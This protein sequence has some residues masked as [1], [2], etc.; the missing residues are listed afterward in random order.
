MVYLCMTYLIHLSTSLILPSAIWI[1]A[2][3][4]IFRCL[5]GFSYENYQ[6]LVE[7]KLSE[8]LIDRISDKLVILFPEY[9][10]SPAKNAPFPAVVEN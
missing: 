1:Y 7:Q 5:R 8:T 2:S 3:S 10:L 6:Q 4:K 9:G